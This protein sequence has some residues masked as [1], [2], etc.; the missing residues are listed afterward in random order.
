MWDGSKFDCVCSVLA[1]I[2]STNC[3]LP[4]PFGVRFQNKQSTLCSRQSTVV[5]GTFCRARS[6]RDL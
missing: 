3:P 5:I 4:V 1:Q 6:R 2:L